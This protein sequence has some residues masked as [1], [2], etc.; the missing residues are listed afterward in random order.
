M[1]VVPMLRALEPGFLKRDHIKLAKANGVFYEGLGNM[2]YKE[3]MSLSMIQIYVL[4]ANHQRIEMKQ[5]K[6]EKK[7]I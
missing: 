4:P 3:L 5:K 7:S 6:E 1:H 2:S